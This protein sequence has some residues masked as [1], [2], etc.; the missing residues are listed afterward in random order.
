MLKALFQAIDEKAEAQIE[1]IREEQDEEISALSRDYDKKR[2]QK[3]RKAKD[4]L[5]AHSQQEV[6]EARKAFELKARFSVERAKRRILEEAYQA[7][8]LKVEQFNESD[9]RKLI[10]RAVNALPKGLSGEAK[11]G[12]KTASVLRALL[13]G[14]QITVSGDLAEE[15]FVLI[16]PNM[17]IDMRFSQ[18]LNQSREKTDPKVLD[19]LFA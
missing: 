19:I 18:L 7:A 8:L 15:G 14:R 10:E 1:K 6:N 4:A 5:L 13:T 11:A 16:T 17:E 2:E 9:F 12:K 3:Y